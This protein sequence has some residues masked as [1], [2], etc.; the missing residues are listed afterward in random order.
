MHIGDHFLPPDKTKR[1]NDSVSNINKIRGG[2]PKTEP[3]LTSLCLTPQPHD[4]AA[5]GNGDFEGVLAWVLCG[6]QRLHEIPE[7]LRA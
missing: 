7:K 3:Y 2:R 6:L 4:S 1:N 5:R